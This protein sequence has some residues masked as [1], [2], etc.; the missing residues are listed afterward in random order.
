LIHI[1][2]DT[3]PAYVGHDETLVPGHGVFERYGRGLRCGRLILI[4]HS[5]RQHGRFARRLR[6]PQRRQR[7]H[8]QGCRQSPPQ[9]QT[10]SL[11]R[12]WLA[13]RFDESIQ[14]NVVFQAWTSGAFGSLSYQTAPLP[15]SGPMIVIPN[16]RSL[17]REESGRAARCVAFFATQ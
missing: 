5:S 6:G 12:M 16:K 8:N 9:L 15:A 1:G 11:C 10:G 2:R 13:N 3:R 7:Q 14:G 17:R 4:L